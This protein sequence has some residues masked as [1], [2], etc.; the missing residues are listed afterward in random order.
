[1]TMNI[2]HLGP[3][4]ALVIGA[5]VV[6]LTAV[7]VP[8]RTQWVTWPIALAATGI[9]AGFTIRLAQTTAQQLT[10]EGAWA[11]DRATQGAELIIVTVTALVLLLGHE[12]MRTDPRAGEYPA[13]VL[14]A[15]TGAMALAG[16]ADTM[17]IVV[18]MLLVSAAGYTLAA[19]HRGSP[20]SV[21]AGMKYFLIGALTNSVL[22]IG[23]VLLYGLAGTTNVGETATVLEVA[24]ASRV[25]LVAVV[26]AIGVGLAFEIGA[27]PA[28]PWVP[29]VAQGAPAP[30]AAFLTV[31]PKI[32]AVVAL[33][34]VFDVLPAASGWRTFVVVLAAVTMTLG[35]LAALW[36]TDLRRLLGWSSV[37]QAGY[38]LM[39]VVVIGRSDMAVPALMYF[40]AGYAVANTAAFGVVTELRGRTRIED[41]RAIASARPL[42]SAVL[43]VALLSLVGIPPLA[44]F[45]GK[46]TLFTVV[47]DAGYG[48]LAA[49]AVANTVVS[50][51]YYLRVIASMYLADDT[52]V[53]TPAPSVLGRWARLA[54]LVAGASV[55]GVGLAAEPLLD[56][57]STARLL[58]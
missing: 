7:F 15:A 31:A 45:V 2:G 4:L 16:A 1:M 25:V 58:P 37:S 19:Y 11:L 56:A 52:A 53:A 34:R 6:V 55:L 28:H 27:A 17:E 42:L 23:V 41:Y 50:L 48:W 40:L 46:L 13:V 24:P 14:F 21:E 26:V 8:R 57:L 39:A 51:Y 47:I 43:A 29:D 44:G 54:T 30:S 49:I 33:A 5:I 38:A 36:Q 12:W 35:N 32:G 22:L 18:G 9:S 20:A 10:F 3:E